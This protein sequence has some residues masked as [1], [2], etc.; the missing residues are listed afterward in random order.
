MLQRG[1]PGRGHGP[2]PHDAR[3]HTELGGGQTGRVL[4]RF[5][6]QSGAQPFE[7][8]TETLRGHGG[9]LRAVVPVHGP[10]VELHK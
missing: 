3:Q 8:V 7:R 5:R 10:N 6:A 2:L 4:S 1:E 9:L